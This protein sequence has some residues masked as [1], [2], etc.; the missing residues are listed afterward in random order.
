MLDF[1]PKRAAA[2]FAVYDGHGGSEV[3]KYCSMHLPEFIL[4][5]PRYTVGDA[6]INPVSILKDAF[7]E[8]D[9]TLIQ[10]KVGV[11]LCVDVDPLPPVF[12]LIINILHV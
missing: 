7:V 4:S 5:R 11:F 12:L 6:A 8:F 1:D 10:P 3:A 2:L 9:T